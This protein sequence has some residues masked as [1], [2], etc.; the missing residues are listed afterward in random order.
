MDKPIHLPESP[1]NQLWHLFYEDEKWEITNLYK[2]EI[3]FNGWNRAI[4]PFVKNVFFRSLKSLDENENLVNAVDMFILSIKENGLSRCSR[5]NQNFIRSMDKIILR[6]K[7]GHSLVVDDFD[8]L[9]N[10]NRNYNKELYNIK[11]M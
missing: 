5:D 6:K 7:E 2:S 11:Q 3:D 1:I 10:M 8:V 9:T 4:V